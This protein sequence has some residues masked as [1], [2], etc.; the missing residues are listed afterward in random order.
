MPERESKILDE[1]GSP[2][3]VALL[4]KEVATPTMTG[5][6]NAW[7]TDSMADGLT[8]SK[9][10]S[11]FKAANE[12]DDF[13]LLTLAEE[14]EER[15]PHYGSVLST[16]KLAV[17]AL[18]ITVEEASEDTKDLEI[19]EEIEKLTKTPQFEVAISDLLDGLGKGR[20]T[21]EIIWAKGEKFTPDFKWRDPRFFKPSKDDPNTLVVK[22]DDNEDGIPI[23]PFKFITHVPKLKTGKLSRSGLARLVAV[24]YMCKSFGLSDW[25]AF[26][27]LFGLPIRVG[28]YGS[29]TT[30]DDK[31]ILKSAVAS[32]GSDAAAIIPDSMRI[33]F[34]ERASSANGDQVFSRLAEWLDKQISKA[35]LGQ[36]ATTEGT[37]GK[38]GSDDAQENVRID[39]IR[40]DAKQLSRTLN[41]QLVKPYV[42]LNYGVPENGYPKIVLFVKDPE[43][44]QL[45]VNAVKDLVPVGLRIKQSEIRDRLNL[46]DPDEG[47]ELFLIPTNVA[48]TN[49]EANT[50]SKPLSQG[51]SLNAEQAPDD[52]DELIKT[53]LD[54]WEKIMSP[55]VD[56]IQELAKNCK[57]QDEFIARLPELLEDDGM[58]PTQ[59]IQSLAAQSFKAKALGDVDDKN[60][61]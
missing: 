37:A 8:P 46:S 45:L 26:L 9:L 31:K 22:D 48:N 44:L 23:P 40:A 43:N 42:D 20:S 15:E 28:R 24:S 27:E 25:M 21:I 11:I 58:N 33:E 60:Q 49:N 52:I 2:I 16:R 29:G 50:T 17:E 55:L 3:K 6:R 10:A 54:D 56:P 51:K 61:L 34:I 57:D 36:T 4:E 5:V 32:I 41:S 13:D 1:N 30:E 7:I 59:L 18:P 12:G 38:L 53:G 47:D 19:A 39:L 14:M 35:V